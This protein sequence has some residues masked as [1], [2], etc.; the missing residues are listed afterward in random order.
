MIKQYLYNFLKY[1]E[2][3]KQLIVRDLKVKYKNSILGMFWSLLNP[4][5]IM[6]I[7]T[8]VFSQLFKF[9]IEHFPVYLL[10]GNIIFNFFSMA[11]S[12]AM[13]SIISNGSL[14]GKIY[15]PKYIFPLSKVC[16]EFVNTLISLAALLLVIIITR[17][18][19]D[20]SAIMCFIPLGYV[21]I[22][23]VGVGLLLSSV[24]VF[25]RD[26]IHLYGV[27]LTAWMYLTPLFYP[28]EIIPKQFIYL[29]YLNPL[30]Y[31]VECF[32]STV[33]YMKL[34]SIELNLVCIGFSFTALILGLLVFYRKQDK[35]ILYV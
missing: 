10:S 23:T 16:F 8:I 26:T 18:P 25:F 29:I 3:L 35:F 30:Y 27:I 4:A 14:M 20:I 6:I 9:N 24:A 32:R 11:S 5:L 22:F 28:I 1:R 33:L 17:V 7:M 34:P 12:A 19:L 15:I 13:T 31:F 2:L 21:F